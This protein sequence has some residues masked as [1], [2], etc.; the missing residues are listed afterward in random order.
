MAQTPFPVSVFEYANTQPVALGY[1]V[2][3]LNKDCLSPI[4]QLSA[5]VK[6]RITLNASGTPVNAPTFWPNSQLQPADVLYIYS[7]Y[8]TL[9]QRVLG[10]VSLVIGLTPSQGFGVAFGSS[11]GS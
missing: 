9:G 5:G 11:F 3:N 7:V 8:T 2:V 1:V 4:G 6:T 10:P